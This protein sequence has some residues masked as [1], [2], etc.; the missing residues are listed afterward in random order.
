[1]KFIKTNDGQLINL[2]LVLYITSWGDKDELYCLYFHFSD[3][4]HK[5]TYFNNEKSF[6]EFTDMLFKKIGL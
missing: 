6:N 3:S 2:E 5:H 4:D 1:M